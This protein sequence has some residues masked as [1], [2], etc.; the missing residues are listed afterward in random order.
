MPYLVELGINAVELL[1]VHEYYVD[2]FLVDRGLTNY[3]GYNSIG[4]FA[5][6]S[7][8]A[9]GTSPGCQVDEFKTL[10][11][12]LHAAGIKVILDVV[13]NHSGEGNE[14]GPTMSLRGIDNPS[15]YLLTG[16]DDEP[17]RY[18][19]NFSGCGNTLDFSSPAVIS[20]VLD[21]LRYW[22]QQMH[23]DGF[24]FDLA[25]VLGRAGDN[26]GFE[27]HAP[28]FEAVRSDPV[29]A[30]SVL[31]A[32]PWDTGTYQ[33]GNFPLGWSEWNGRFRDTMRRFVKGDDGQLP[34]LGRRLTG[35][36]DL[37]A[38]D[39]RTAYN[40]INFITCHDGFTLN[41]LVSFDTKH[42]EANGEQNRDGSDDN[43]SWNCGVEGD[44][45]D[46]EITFLRR[47]LVKNHLCRLLFSAGTP[48]LLGGD[49]FLRT[50][51]GNNNAYCQDNEISWFDWDLVERN[52]DILEFAKRAISLTR[53]FKTLQHAKYVLGANNDA[54]L[55][56][57]LT[58]F[59]PDGNLPDWSNPH[60]HTLCFQL[61]TAD[62]VPHAGISSLY[63]ILNADHQN[64]W[65]VLPQL[66]DGQ[67]W[68]RVVDTSLPAGEDFADPGSEV[69]VDPDDHYLA[70]ARAAVILAARA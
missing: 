48:M 15:Y 6:E 46:H 1:P 43:N 47:Q 4:F 9:T 7:S 22:V 61:D 45:D 52:R 19:M 38:D 11:R 64:A 24:R 12:G 32:E 16:S 34:D 33:V 70:S 67:S 35:S 68:Y 41:D 21:S 40:S 51:H 25:A 14:M 44:T 65:I 13:F 27:A 49:E 57:E 10:V 39:G 28:L 3:W 5:P 8:Y 58:W 53:R 17:G 63:L 18:Y 23:V 50:Q 29:L 31:I 20:L 69:L 2:D 60:A 26:D 36:A 59:G 55:V 42:N 66:T 56:D 37:Y 62:A 30:Q 54:G